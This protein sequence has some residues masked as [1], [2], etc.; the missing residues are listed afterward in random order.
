MKNMFHL[1]EQVDMAIAILEENGYEAYIVGGCVRDLIIG[2]TPK[3]YDITSNALPS[4]VMYVFRKYRIIETGLK[5]GTVTVILQHMPIEITTYRIDGN[6]SDNRHPDNVDFTKS[7]S[8]DL[9]RRDFTM[10]AIAYNHK[11]GMIDIYGGKWDI[12]NKIIR[13]VGNAEER[14]AEDA[15]RILR[16]ARFSSTL[17]FEIEKQTSGSMKKCCGLLQNIAKERINVE[18]SKLL[19][20]VGVR[21]VLL[22]FMDVIATF[23]PE[24]MSL[25]EFDIAHAAN[26]INN[27]PDVLNLRLCALFHDISGKMARDIL[28][29]L[30]FDKATIKSVYMLVL[31]HDMKIELNASSLKRWLN[32]LSEAVVR[33][34]ITLKKAEML[35]QSSD[36]SFGI[37]HLDE[38]ID[39]LDRIIKEQ[40]CYTIQNLAI[41]G[42]D[43]IELGILE[44]K[45]VGNALNYLLNCVIDNNNLNT[46]QNLTY[47][48]LQKST[49]SN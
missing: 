15:L 7:L 34:I 45:E 43:L 42:N 20:G 6:Y 10:N 48:I 17:N 39:L 9:K 1:P 47:L 46:K 5:H 31:Y 26:V 49:V 30:K 44:G 27:T 36:N 14:F 37:Q 38:L 3:D 40:E 41:N 33:D 21:M 4:E 11:K 12:E 32:K 18:L 16:A 23:I 28:T 29:R 13:C 22:N 8:E 24:I 19:C 25:T 35:A 2:V